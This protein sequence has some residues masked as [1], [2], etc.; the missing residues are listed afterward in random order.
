MLKEY[1]F[2]TERRKLLRLSFIYLFKKYLILCFDF[3]F[4]TVKKL[5]AILLTLFLDFF[6]VHWDKIILQTVFVIL[7]TCP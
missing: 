5:S 2:Q 7:A 4:R 1:P 6:T 3:L